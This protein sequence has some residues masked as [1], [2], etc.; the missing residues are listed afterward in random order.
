MFGP[1]W[2]NPDAVVGVCGALALARWGGMPPANIRLM[3]L[4]VVVVVVVVIFHG[5]HLPV[6]QKLRLSAL[7]IWPFSLCRR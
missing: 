3:P 1:Y 7:D 5:F 2:T 4:A 6:E